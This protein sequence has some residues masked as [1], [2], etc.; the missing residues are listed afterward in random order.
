MCNSCWPHSDEKSRAQP[1]LIMYIEAERGSNRERWRKKGIIFVRHQIKIPFW[2][3]EGLHRTAIAG[4]CCIE[5]RPWPSLLW[6]AALQDSG[7]P[8]LGSAAWPG[9]TRPPINSEF[10]S[11]LVKLHAKC[12]LRLK[13]GRPATCSV[14]EKGHLGSC[15]SEES[16][17]LAALSLIDSGSHNNDH[18]S[19]L[20][21]NIWK[22]NA[23][24][25]KNW[26]Y[27]TQT[28]HAQIKV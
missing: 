7:Q 27:I 23:G 19:T 17:W 1:S 25:N 6:V 21:S 22:K 4:H 13:L 16:P 20:N 9:N 3:M 14:T 12:S 18:Q 26:T 24:T 11:A 15:A 2:C 8:A 28:V 10:A 5:S